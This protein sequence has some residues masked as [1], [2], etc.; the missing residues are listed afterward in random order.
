MGE[1]NVLEHARLLKRTE[2][3]RTE[4]AA[5]KVKPLDEPAHAAH[6]ARL[7]LHLKN[8]RQHRLISRA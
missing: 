2:E 5:L 4:H 8:L 6:K 7:A 3:L 1:T